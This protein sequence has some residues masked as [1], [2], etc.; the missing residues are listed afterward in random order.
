MNAYSSDTDSIPSKFQIGLKGGISQ[1][2]TFSGDVSFGFVFKLNKK[3]TEVNAGYTYFNNTTDFDQ[4]EDLLYFSHGLFGEINFFLISNFYAGARLS[5]NMNF[6]DEESQNK[7]SRNSDR[8][9]PTYFTGMS[10][11]GQLGY[12]Q[13]IGKSF[14]IRLQG[15]IGVHNYRMAT[16]ALY[17]STLIPQGII[18]N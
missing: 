12:S 9:P 7:Y 18:H 16:G 1:N 5:V 8:D 3:R 11:C 6:V 2:N 13:P 14:C 10:A 17:Y 15:Q 4:V